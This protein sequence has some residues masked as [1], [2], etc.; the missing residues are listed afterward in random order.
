MVKS[1]SRNNVKRTGAQGFQFR[2]LMGFGVPRLC[3]FPCLRGTQSTPLEVYPSE[4]IR[5]SLED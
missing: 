5:Y 1:F 3:L 2:F 4:V